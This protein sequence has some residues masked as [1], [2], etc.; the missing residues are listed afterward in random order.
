L[1]VLSVELALYHPSGSLKIG[2]ATTFMVDLCAPLLNISA[3]TTSARQ[4]STLRCIRKIAKIDYQLRHVCPSVRQHGTTW[5]P[6]YKYS[7]NLYLS[8]FRK[9]FDNI[10][11]S[12]KSD[13]N[14]RYFIFLTISRSFLISIEMI[15]TKAVDEIKKHILCPIT[16]LFSKIVPFVRQ[17]GKI[18]YSQAGHRR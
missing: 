3:L 9:S 12:L 14:N 8:I 16:F 10:Q 7:W 4:T 11:V 5:L 1:C 2:M 6:L 15:Q 13:K 17:C 18:S